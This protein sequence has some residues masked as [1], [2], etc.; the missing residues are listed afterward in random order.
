MLQSDRATGP[1]LALCNRVLSQQDFREPLSKLKP[2]GENVASQVEIIISPSCIHK[3]NHNQKNVSWGQESKLIF[4][5]L[6]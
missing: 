2:V 4:V 3:L 1:I 5:N 6:H